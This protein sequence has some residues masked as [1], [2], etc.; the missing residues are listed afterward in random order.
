MR[1]IFIILSIFALS[2]ANAFSLKDKMIKGQ[3][4]DYIVTTQG[5]MISVLLI[6]S[7]SEKALQL[8]E[9]S[10]PKVILPKMGWKE[11]IEK[12]APGHT[13]WIAY[14]ID[15]KDNRLIE[16]Y[17][18][19]RR[20]WLFVDD[21]NHFLT[22]LLTLNLKRTPENARKRIGPATADEEF[23]H[24]AFWSPP[25]VVE[26]KKIEKPA[27]TPWSGKWPSDGSEIAGSEVELYFGTSPF[28]YWIDIKTPHYQASI[29]TL[30]SGS[31]MNSPKPLLPRR[32]PEFLGH[33]AWQNH[34]I[35]VQ[36]QCPTYYEKLNLFVI[37]LSEETPAP[38]PLTCTME[39]KSNHVTLSISEETLQS[40]LKKDHKYRWIVVPENSSEILAES[41]DIFVW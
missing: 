41:D 22:K 32:P 8:E 7:I 16:C 12:N 3:P 24:R 21:P 23:D 39:R 1:I 27:I 37:D 10:I 38:I 31:H 4:G 35:I 26:G 13:S 5:N 25:V 28:P 6:R 2:I 40:T 34:K 30:D 11:W 15:L 14:E 19:S 33:A 9:I 29:R 20:E 36:L 18:H 17:S